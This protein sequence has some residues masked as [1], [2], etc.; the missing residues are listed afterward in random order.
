[1]LDRF[2]KVASVTRGIAALVIG[3]PVLLLM[4]VM[5][6]IYILPGWLPIIAAVIVFGPSIVYT[7]L[8]FLRESAPYPAARFA[9]SLML[10]MVADPILYS[11]SIG[12]G[13][14]RPGRQIVIYGLSVAVG[15]VVWRLLG[16]I[17]NEKDLTAPNAAG[18]LVGIFASCCIILALGHVFPPVQQSIDFIGGIVTSELSSDDANSGP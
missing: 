4:I 6:A 11:A 8:A 13:L 1:M 16:N 9:V 7:R 17:K 2:K 3:I 14:Y 15:Y 12:F 10:A 5:G 18:A